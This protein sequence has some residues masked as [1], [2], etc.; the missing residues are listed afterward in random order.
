[1]YIVLGVIVGILVLTAIVTAHEWGHFI[2]A[3]RSGVKVNEFGIGFPPRGAAWL[4]VPISK[5]KTYCKK[6]KFDEKRTEKY[7]KKAERLSKRAQKKEKYIWIKF[8]KSEWYEETDDG[9]VPKP[10]DYLIFSLNLLP[11]GGFCA[12]D[13]ESDSDTRKGTFGATTYW[14]K[15]KI[16]F[17]G[18]LM[19]WLLAIV[20]FT[21]LAWT[22]MPKL[23]E[24]QYVGPLSH[25]VGAPIRVEEVIEGSPADNAGIEVG[26]LISEARDSENTYKIYTPQDLVSFNTTHAGQTVSY[27][28]YHNLS[29]TE[30]KTDTCDWDSSA[31][32]LTN[33]GEAI[34][35]KCNFTL[36]E[37]ALNP[38]GSEYSLG[39]A[40]S[41]TANALTYSTFDA[42]LVGVVTTT[43]ITGETFKGLGSLVYNLFSGVINQFSGDEATR[44]EGQ[45]KL[46]SAGDSVSGPVGII[47]Q[48][49]PAFTSLGATYVAFLA[50]LISVSLACMN[51]L[52]IPALDGGR[53][54]LIT[55]FRARK[56]RLTQETESKIVSRA[57]MVILILAA[58][59]TVLDV[60]R[61]FK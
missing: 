48:L 9:A 8:P 57:M 10:Q 7:T 25:M 46:Q 55:L 13:G 40:M 58:L 38:E 3:K 61:I 32:D 41:Q 43:Q 33:N 39:V 19:N 42:P 18:V 31:T 60:I 29:E 12:M 45:E 2:M 17:G 30:I 15:T 51:V 20:I 1:M 34:D 24:N 36:T 5:V 22:G 21:M 14:Q 35:E 50:A 52:P 23:L 53:W 4:H 56:K 26:A 49:F 59:I 27:K 44:T 37:V 47:G 16:L 54:F 28:I 11:I 6:F